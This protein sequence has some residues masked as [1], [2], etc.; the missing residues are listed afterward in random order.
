MAD[1]LPDVGQLA[2]ELEALR[3]QHR[4]VGEVLRSVARADG[5]ETVLHT[6]VESERLAK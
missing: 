6:V 4:A 2:R 3:E 5:L 1:A